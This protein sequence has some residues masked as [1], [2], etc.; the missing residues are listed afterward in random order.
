MTS[1]SS[2]IH[3]NPQRKMNKKRKFKNW[4]IV[5]DEKIIHFCTS[6]NCIAIFRASPYF[7]WTWP[8]GPGTGPNSG[9]EFW[10]L[11][12]TV[13]TTA[14]A[15][16]AATNN[17]RNHPQN[18]FLL[19]RSPIFKI[20]QKLIGIFQQRGVNVEEKSGIRDNANCRIGIGLCLIWS[21]GMD[22]SSLNVVDNEGG[23]KNHRQEGARRTLG[24]KDGNALSD[25]FLGF[26]G[27]PFSGI[28]DGLV[29]F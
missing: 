3:Q 5:G 1:N 9:S 12:L 7:F 8:G 26:V 14:M 15:I 23:E 21:I 16:T 27:F 2:W 18:P 11:F 19:E 4:E 20:Q 28:L 24:W 25:L 6:K 13:I 10:L 22:G 29:S 17:T